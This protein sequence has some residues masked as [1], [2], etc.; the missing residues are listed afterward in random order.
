MTAS[1][2]KR[3]FAVAQNR[4]TLACITLANSALSVSLKLGGKTMATANSSGVLAAIPPPLKL[5]ETFPP[6]RTNAA[7]ELHAPILFTSPFR[8]L[9]A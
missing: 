5:T 3:T 9:R 7:T 8:P 1:D 4:Q 2:P 6:L